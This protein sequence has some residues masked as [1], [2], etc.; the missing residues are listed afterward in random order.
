VVGSTR[1]AAKA[2]RSPLEIG[3]GSHPTIFWCSLPRAGRSF[4]R[5][6]ITSYAVILDLPPAQQ[7]ERPQPRRNACDGGQPPERYY[8]RL[9]VI[10]CMPYPTLCKTVGGPQRAKPCPNR[11]PAV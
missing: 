11:A 5:A 8:R 1:A 7:Y 4:S 6:T 2:S 10:L 3:W 9:E